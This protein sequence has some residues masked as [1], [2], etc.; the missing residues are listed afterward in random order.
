MLKAILFD[1]DHTLYDRFK[2]LKISLPDT[3][4]LMAEYLTDDL[5]YEE[6]E[7]EMLYAEAEYLYD[8]SP[9]DTAADRWGRRTDYLISCGIL[10]KYI[11]PENFRDFV[12]EPVM[13][14]IVHY[15]Y[16]YDFLKTLR[17]KYKIG[18]VTNGDSK[19]Q[20]GKVDACKF[21]DKFDYICVC[22]DKGVQKPEA[23]PFIE[24]AK[25]LGLEPYECIYVGDNP[26]NDIL[27]AINAGMASVFIKTCGPWRYD[28]FQKA[29]FEVDEVGDIIDILPQI[30][31]KLAKKNK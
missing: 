16:I 7:R 5:P 18:I 27:G 9:E 26:K 22:G 6:F 1:L 2:T 8:V 20:W 10:K 28:K 19:L 23:E 14:K 30:E 24:A 31:E 25:E 4:K 29:D 17:S 3:Y 11:S 13:D 15:D 12:N 21:R